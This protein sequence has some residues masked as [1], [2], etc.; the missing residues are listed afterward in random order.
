MGK[1]ALGVHVDLISETVAFL[2]VYTSLTFST[3]PQWNIYF[4]KGTGC[5]I[6]SEKYAN[7]TLCDPPW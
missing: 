7:G 2:E 1:P 4:R 5:R 6:A 3:V